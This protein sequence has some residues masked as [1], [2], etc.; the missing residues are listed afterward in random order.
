MESISEHEEQRPGFSVAGRCE[1][2]CSPLRPFGY[3][4]ICHMPALRLPDKEG[5]RLFAAVMG[6][7]CVPRLVMGNAGL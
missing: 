3:G 5:I 6:T 4:P 1:P 7:P 2:A